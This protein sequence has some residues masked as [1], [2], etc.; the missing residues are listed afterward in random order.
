MTSPGRTRGWPAGIAF[1]I[2][3][4]SAFGLAPALAPFP[5]SAATPGL[6]ITSDASYDVLPDEGRVAVTAH[7]TATNH[8]RNTITK[9]YFFRTAFLTVQPGTSGYT[10]TGGS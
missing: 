2:G 3:L 10:L 9:R 5:A 6:T 1:L 4:A 8:L 7:L